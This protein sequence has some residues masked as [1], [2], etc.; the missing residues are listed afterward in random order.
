MK[1]KENIILKEI[2]RKENTVRYRFEVSEAIRPYFTTNEMFV[3]YDDG[4]DLSEIPDSIL[5]IPFVGSVIALSWLIDAVLWVKDIDDTFYK[6]ARNLKLAYSELYPHY[7]FGGRFVA[8]NRHFNTISG[9]RSHES[10][11]LLLFSG[12]IDAHTSYLRNIGKKPLLCNIQGWLKDPESESKAQKSDFHDIHE[13]ARREGCG[14]ALVKSNFATVVDGRY[15]SKSLGKKIGDSWWHGFQHSMSFISIAIPVAYHYGIAEILIA[16]SHSIG[17]KG[18][19]ASYPTTDTEFRFATRG[20]TVHDAFEMTRQDKVAF[21]VDFQKRSDKPY[22]IRVCSFN[23]H[24]C[25]V[26]VKCFRTIL[27]IISEGGDI[28]DFGFYKPENMRE[29]YDKYIRSHYI[30]FGINREALLFWPEIK[31]R[32]KENYNTIEEKDFVD[33]FNSVDFVAERKKAVLKYRIQ[34]FFPL[35]RKKLMGSDFEAKR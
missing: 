29:Y 1:I 27:E 28:A 34:N 14:E 12:G 10:E 9:N 19:C 21:I 22:P 30:E 3:S 35:L 24:N 5:A 16:S 4:I 20:Y 25:G 15:F 6:S 2:V 26:C 23:D 32:I 13:F 18:I 8:A 7:K 11:A 17:S 33:W 31:R